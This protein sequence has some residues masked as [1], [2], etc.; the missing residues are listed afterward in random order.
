MKCPSCKI[1]DL[2]VITLRLG[3]EPVVLRSCS[4]CN[5]RDWEG[6]DGPMPLRTVLDLVATR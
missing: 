4:S 5:R 2:V 3:A 6:L 1:H